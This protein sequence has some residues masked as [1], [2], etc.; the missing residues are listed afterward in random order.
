MELVSVII[1]VYNSENCLQSCIESIQNQEHENIEIILI[2]DG[3]TD[4][5]PII[6]DRCAEMD[7]RIKVIHQEN[8]G[9]SS[10]RNAGIEIARGKHIVFVDSDDTIEMTHLLLLEKEDSDIDLVVCGVKQ[11]S[12]TGMMSVKTSYRRQL[13]PEVNRET[14]LEMIKNNALCYVY[15]KRFDRDIIMKENIRFSEG[16][17]LGEDT[18]FVAKYMNVCRNIQYIEENTYIYHRYQ[19]E[20]LSSFKID[21]IM[22]LA[23]VNRKI[24]SILS[25]RFGNIEETE[26]WKKRIFGIYPYGI[27]NIL[28]SKKYKKREKYQSLKS[29][30]EIKEFKEFVTKLDIYMNNE[31]EIIRKVIATRKPI[32][33]IAFWDL[34]TIKKRCNGRIDD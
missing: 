34:L 15:D 13:I 10:A 23:N 27:F 11:M 25:E 22:L 17:N 7:K 18:E 4:D 24:G 2:D 31:S 26:E 32:V 20:T 6:C 9:V 8:K 29:I 21:C 19:N 1:P 14:V 28:Q 30:F 16:I 33:V 3:S 12:E 5:S